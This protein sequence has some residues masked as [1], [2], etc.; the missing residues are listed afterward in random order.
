M[1]AGPQFARA[2]HLRGF[3][4]FVSERLLTGRLAEINEY[5]IG[6]EVLG[7]R[8]TFN[9]HEDNIVRVQARHLRAKLEQH[10]AAEGKDEPVIVT[11]PRGI[12]RSR[13][14]TAAAAEARRRD[15][16]AAL[17]SRLSAAGRALPPG[18]CCCSQSSRWQ[19][20]FFA[21]RPGP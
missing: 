13:V 19:P 20:G 3:L 9:P 12:V 6:R 8:A 7:R 1:V 21:A 16:G 11:I 18:L 14:R 17:R 2:P 5:E 15:A 4:L 10:F